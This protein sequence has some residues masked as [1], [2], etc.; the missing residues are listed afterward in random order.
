MMLKILVVS[1]AFIAIVSILLIFPGPD[2]TDIKEAAKT[3]AEGGG[4]PS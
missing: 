3:I 1:W 2:H 4:N